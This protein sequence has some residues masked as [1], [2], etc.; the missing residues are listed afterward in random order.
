VTEAL[1]DENSAVRL[2]GIFR[3]MEIRF[4]PLGQGFLHPFAQL[5]NVVK[6]CSEND[7]LA[8]VHIPALLIG[9]G[10]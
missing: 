9:V 5:A 7:R 1:L 10:D 3:L 2:V 8:S 4:D 6:K